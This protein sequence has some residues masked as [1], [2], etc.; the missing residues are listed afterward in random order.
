MFEFPTAGYYYT[1]QSPFDLA[2][3]LK[4]YDDGFW[5]YQD[6]FDFEF[7]FP[8]YV[9]SLDVASLKRRYPD[10]TCLRDEQVGN[11]LFRSSCGRYKRVSDIP[12]IAVDGREVGRMPDA[13][14]LTC[15]GSVSAEIEIIGDGRLENGILIAQYEFIPDGAK[16]QIPGYWKRR[17]G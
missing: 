2:G 11:S 9:E 8:N 7:D 3:F 10:G 5:I 16:R 13:L 15:G 14:V 17:Q 6:S 12:M 1:V 4:F